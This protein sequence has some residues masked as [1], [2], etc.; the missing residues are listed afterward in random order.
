MLRE[1]PQQGNSRAAAPRRRP[2]NQKD[3]GGAA[4]PKQEQQHNKALNLFT[5]LVT[6]RKAFTPML[7]RSNG[8]ERA[9]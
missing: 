6:R 1:L 7:T 5:S 2:V 8:A 9:R 3:R 4:D